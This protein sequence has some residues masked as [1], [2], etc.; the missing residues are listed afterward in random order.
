MGAG[1][2]GGLE[3]PR[4][5][6]GGGAEHSAEDIGTVVRINDCCRAGRSAGASSGK[7][8]SVSL[9]RADGGVE[10]HDIVAVTGAGSSS[11]IGAKG[12]DG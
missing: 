5:V 6:S 2:P 7:V 9:G 3:P 8:C 1:E 4:R 10:G 11:S 12:T